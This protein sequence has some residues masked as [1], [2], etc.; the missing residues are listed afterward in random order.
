VTDSS[1]RA[2]A[3]TTRLRESLRPGGEF[4]AHSVL[5]GPV[6]LALDP[7]VKV[8]GI[9]A[10]GCRVFKS[11]VSPALI[12]LVVHDS[13]DPAFIKE[14]FGDEA[15]DAFLA[16]RARRGSDPWDERAAVRTAGAT[17]WTYDVLFKIGDD[18]RQDQ[19][20]LQLLRLMDEHFQSLS[21][22]FC[23]TPYRVLATST[24]T[25]L[26]EFV[27]GAMPLDPIKGNILGWL[28]DRPGNRDDQGLK[29]VRLDVVER[30][31]RSCAGY[32]VWTYI[33]GVG[34]RHL[35]NIMITPDGRLIHIDFGYA[36][37][38]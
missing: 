8:C 5:S 25:G 34:D 6:L 15:M 13:T 19:L 28:A 17:R 21:L 2:D 16:V 12:P 4:G 18:V 23:L 30:Y 27:T 38:K 36:F 22:D 10:D 7:R 29:G 31:T 3:K 37:G 26:L 14:R 24:T 32:C 20:L 33:L 9:V 35:D 11:S 1:L